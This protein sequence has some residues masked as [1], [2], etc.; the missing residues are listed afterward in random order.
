[1]VSP[2]KNE[3][4]SF[5]WY[6]RSASVTGHE[7]RSMPSMREVQFDV[8]DLSATNRLAARLATVTR[9]SLVVALNG[10]LG[11]G[12]TKFVQCFAQAL[13]V[14]EV[15]NSPTFTMMNEYHSGRIPLYHLDLYRLGESET[16]NAVQYLEEELSE[17]LLRPHAI[18][19]EWA[20]L[21]SKQTIA[22]PPQSALTASTIKESKPT[23]GAEND[24]A[25]D[26]NFLNR[27]DHLVATF[28]YN[29]VLNENALTSSSSLYKHQDNHQEGRR[30][31][32]RAI[33]STSAQL[34]GALEKEMTREA[35]K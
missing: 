3:S 25:P 16:L 20:E 15:V 21:L 28:S 7:L 13:G 19:I 33:G 31:S 1:M 35:D 8:E 12:K 6:D 18:L 2:S 27:L 30:V 34:L 9:Q 4:Y 14:E 23:D 5:H 10:P 29:E 22:A 26:M 11:V 17:I 32:F 24:F